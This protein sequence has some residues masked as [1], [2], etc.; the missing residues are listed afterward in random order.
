MTVACLFLGSFG[1]VMLDVAGGLPFM[2][3]VKP[4]ERSEMAAVYS[5]FRDVSGI[6]TPAM[7]WAV[8]SVAPLAACRQSPPMK[9][10]LREDSSEDMPTDCHALSAFVA[11]G[12]P[13]SVLGTRGASGCSVSRS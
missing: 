10:E 5:S 9:L 2:M 4:S 11:A 7:A 1:L 13:I 12:E 3:A 8:L 6:A